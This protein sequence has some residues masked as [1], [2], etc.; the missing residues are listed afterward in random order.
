MG[1]L[2]GIVECDNFNAEHSTD[3]PLLEPNQLSIG[4]NLKAVVTTSYLAQH[5]SGS[6]LERERA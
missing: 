2:A 5:Y 6:H 1:A 3:G 4:I